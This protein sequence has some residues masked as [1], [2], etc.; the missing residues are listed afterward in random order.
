MTT[1]PR[2]WTLTGAL[3]WVGTGGFL[4]GLFG[5]VLAVL[6]TSFA[7]KWT[8]T[9][10]PESLT[11][12]WYRLAWEDYSVGDLLLVTLQVALAVVV[13]SLVIAVPTAYVLSR[14]NFPGKRLLLLLFLL[15]QVIPP[16]TYGIPL[17]TVMY[18]YHL[19]ETLLGV[20]LVNLVPSVPFAVLVLVPF[21]EQIDP[22][23]EQA[24]RVCGAGTFDVFRRV[25]VPLLVPGL[26]AAGVLVLVRTVGMFELTFLVAGPDSQTLVVALFYAAASPG[27]QSTQQIDAMAV[28]YMLTTLVMLLV[29]LRFVDPTLGVRRAAGSRD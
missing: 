4:L 24:A 11:A 16:M 22:R 21:I 12:D 9:W 23:V 19:A 5:A 20:V 17:A 29:A 6:L 10:L 28:I 7:A 3:T 1:R 26:L 2:R 13:L 25:L 8:G 27:L 18:K 14:L 15:P